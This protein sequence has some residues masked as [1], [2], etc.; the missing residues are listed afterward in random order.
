MEEH[1]TRLLD[2]LAQ[3]DFAGRYYAYYDTC[4]GRSSMLGFCKDALERALSLTGLPFRYRKKEN[5][6][7]FVEKHQTCEI[8]L[9]V[10]SPHSAV[11]LILVFKV[12][13]GHLGSPFPKLARQIEQRRDPAFNFTPASPKLPFSNF[14]ELCDSVRFGVSLFTDAKRVL[15]SQDWEC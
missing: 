7:S 14:E 5:F 12:K 4:R 2:L 3:I 6:F 9:N 10:A 8:G 11:E 13:Q 1:F 15:L